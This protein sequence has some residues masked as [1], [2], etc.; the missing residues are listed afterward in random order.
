MCMSGHQLTTDLHR[1]IAPPRH[2]TQV[3][4]QR[5]RLR[6]RLRRRALRV[7]LGSGGGGGGA[8]DSL[9]RGAEG[10]ARQ[11]PDGAQGW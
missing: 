6:L 11:G 8:F 1:T 7:G 10:P 4:C 3:F 9:G 5:G 2:L